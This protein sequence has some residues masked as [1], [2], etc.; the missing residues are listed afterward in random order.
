VW[1]ESAWTTESF[2]IVTRQI[3]ASTGC[4]SSAVKMSDRAV[5]WR[6]RQKPDARPELR[7]MTERKDNG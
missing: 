3:S 6:K 4:A 5:L 7:V 2:P 1:N